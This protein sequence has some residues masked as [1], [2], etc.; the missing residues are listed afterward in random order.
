MKK[1][2]FALSILAAATLCAEPVS[3]QR[4]AKVATNFM[5]S[6]INS[7][8]P[9][10]LTLHSANWYYT[11]I[12]L[13]ENTGGGWVLVA[14]E[15]C[16]KPILGY[17]TSGRLDPTNMPPALKQWLAGYEEQ[18]SAIWRARHLKGNIA[19]YPEDAKEWQRL[20]EGIIVDGTKD[21]TRVEPLIT[22]H[23]DQGYPYNQMCPR[24][25]VTGC[26][27][28]AMAMYLKFWNYPA[29]G[30]G[31]YSYNSPRTGTT[32]SADFGHTIYD[33]DNM[34]DSTSQYDTQ[35]EIDAIATLMYHCGVSLAMDYGTA[36]SGGSSAIGIVGQSGF[37]SID[38]A[39]KDYF[40]FSPDM[41]ACFKDYG[42]T[43]DSWRAMLVAELDEGRPI[44]YCGS[45][46]QGGHGFIC[47]G[48]D[49]RQYMHFNFGWSGTGDGYYPV[50]S[51]SPGVG[52]VGGN[53]TYT[54]NLQNACLIGAIPDYA[55][56]VSDTIWNYFAEGGSDSLLVGINEMS[57]AILEIST[58]ADW[59]NVEY[60]EINRAGWVRFNVAPMTDGEERVAYIVFTQ[61]NESVR[62]KVVQVNY[63][64]EEMCS[65]TVVM[66]N[67]STHY[68]GWM[69]GAF[70]TLESE[71]GFI[72]GTARLESVNRDS[73]VIRVAPQNVHCVWHSGGGSDRYVNYWVRNQYGEDFISVVNAYRNGGNNIIPWSCAHVAINEVAQ[74]KNEIYPNPA[75]NV[76][77]ISTNGLQKVEII[78]LS[79][80]K[81]TESHSR[82]VDISQLPNG[83][84]FARIITVNG[85]F[86]RRFIKR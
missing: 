83:H 35:E 12:Y 66:E 77:N 58:T 13:F 70:L 43:N 32:E 46:R 20:E 11:S 64:D 40:C 2:I 19:V 44:I 18:I 3:P 34:P 65:L 81:I 75:H 33:W 22:S 84:Y 50:D 31:S 25:T 16:V 86:V 73:V 74:Q 7:K 15:D 29:F 38:N 48:Y 55:L 30:R 63:T 4:A 14:N 54:F 1:I 37:S 6:K 9:I 8:A 51:I 49:E 45:A 5:T 60:G 69:E 23:W 21:D 62:V 26:A 24:G 27:A 61:G 76:I 41:T 56:S 52:G 85:T 79:G 68:D 47:D 42:Y 36:A 53:V 39:L 67:S 10:E 28:T 72:F 59:L 80:R 57:N 71:G 17:S 82:S 78:D